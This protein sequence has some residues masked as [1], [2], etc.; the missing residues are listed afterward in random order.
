MKTRAPF[1]ST[2]TP[3]SRRRFL[4]GT[5]AALA[6]PMLDAMLPSFAR[7]AAASSPLAPG[8][9]VPRRMFAVCNNLGLLAQD[10]FPAGASG[11][12]YVASAYLQPLQEFRN[13]FTVFSGV[14]HPSVDSGH[15]AD[16]CFL[17]AAPH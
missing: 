9:G 6:L 4:Q 5:G 2:R 11:R 15:P 17:S 14:S 10:F 3:L 13:A 16:V 12:D 7:A 8:G 1:I